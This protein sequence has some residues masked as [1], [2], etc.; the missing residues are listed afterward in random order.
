MKWGD[1]RRYAFDITSTTALN[2]KPRLDIQGYTFVF[3]ALYLS[4]TTAIWLRHS[5]YFGLFVL[6]RINFAP[7]R[8][9][10]HSVKDNFCDILDIVSL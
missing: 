1:C 5:S 4:L 9:F 6:D 7:V 8:L 3:A 10:T 2:E